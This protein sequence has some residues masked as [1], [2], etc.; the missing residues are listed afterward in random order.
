MGQRRT[1]DCWPLQKCAMK[2][3][4]SPKFV[5][6]WR[7]GDHGHQEVRLRMEDISL[8]RGV[9]PIISCI[10]SM[11]MEYISSQRPH[12]KAKSIV[13]A[14]VLPR[15]TLKLSKNSAQKIPLTSATLYRTII[16]STSFGH[17][18]T[19]SASQARCINY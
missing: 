2:L 5:L 15:S 3:Q 6:C 11:Q 7:K 13:L 8:Q 19:Q 1:S 17:G 18:S 16:L 14:K 4:K 9:E 10:I 12:H